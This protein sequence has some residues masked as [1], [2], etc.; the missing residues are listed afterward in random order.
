MITQ[1]AP[2]LRG[3]YTHLVVQEDE[4]TRCGLPVLSVSYGSTAEVDC[5]ACLRP[6][7]RTCEGYLGRLP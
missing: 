1:T 6:D 4:G 5:P 7:F 3:A 2:L